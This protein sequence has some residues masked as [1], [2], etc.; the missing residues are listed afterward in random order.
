[1]SSSSTTLVRH[2][3][4]IHETIWLI[5][6]QYLVKAKSF[7]DKGNK[8]AGLILTIRHSVLPHADASAATRLTA[9]NQSVMRPSGQARCTFDGGA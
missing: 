6:I 3:K 2:N 7:A 1:M 4:P 5:S 9:S 8:R